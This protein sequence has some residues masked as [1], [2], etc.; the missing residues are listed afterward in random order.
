MDQECI[1]IVK[2]SSQEILIYYYQ[3]PRKGE[4]QVMQIHTEITQ[5][6]FLEHKEILIGYQDG[7]EIFLYK[8]SKNILV[9]HFDSCFEPYMSRTIRVA[10]PYISYISSKDSVKVIKDLKF[11]TLI[12]QSLVLKLEVPV[13]EKIIDHR[14]VPQGQIAVVIS[15]G[16]WVGVFSLVTAELLSSQRVDCSEMWAMD[17]L[18]INLLDDKGPYYTG[19]TSPKKNRSGGAGRSNGGHSWQERTEETPGEGSSRDQRLLRSAQSVNHFSVNLTPIKPPDSTIPS[20]I[21]GKAIELIK[22]DH[23]D[24]IYQTPN[25]KRLLRQPTSIKSKFKMKR[26][27]VLSLIDLEKDTTIQVFSIDQDGRFELMGKWTRKLKFHFYSLNFRMFLKGLP[28][29]VATN[30]KGPYHVFLFV[31]NE[32]GEIFGLDQEFDLRANYEYSFDMVS[33]RETGTVVTG[34][35]TKNIVLIRFNEDGG[36]ED[37]GD[38]LEALQN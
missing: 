10:G 8:P 2:E 30:E 18:D 33:C 32:D 17:I 1:W 15:E 19:S 31:V 36:D 11:D 22:G 24:Q 28:L 23:M 4:S 37:E 9:E 34:G 35:N 7:T 3:G 38:G 14:V 29:V 25:T 13:R 5:C 12:N 6:R 20:Q 21:T 27:G 26:F 16:G